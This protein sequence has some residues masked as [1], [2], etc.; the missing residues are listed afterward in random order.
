MPAKDARV[1]RA[2]P[3]ATVAHTPLFSSAPRAY[4]VLIHL[5]AVALDVR[6]WP[7]E[8]RLPYGVD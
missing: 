4:T 8:V 7:I 6:Q 1:T 2:Y 3:A 5:A